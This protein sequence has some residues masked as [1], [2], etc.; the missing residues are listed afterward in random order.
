M[1]TTNRSR[2]TGFF[3]PTIT[4]E[5]KNEVTITV[6]DNGPLLMNGTVKVVLKDGSTIIKE[7]NTALCRCGQSK[8]KPY[9]DGAHR[10][11][12]FLKDA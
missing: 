11:C 8:N 3:N 12:D 7:G 6:L 4:M 9:C 5:N 1:K 10:T 2:W